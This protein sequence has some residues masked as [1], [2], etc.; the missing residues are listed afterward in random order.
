MNT[1]REHVHV[2]VRSRSTPSPSTAGASRC[3]FWLPAMVSCTCNAHAHAMHMHM[4]CTCNA[5]AAMHM[6]PCIMC[7]RPLL[8]LHALHP[9]AGHASRPDPGD[10]MRSTF[11][12]PKPFSSHLS[13]YIS[14]HHRYSTYHPCVLLDYLPGTF[15]AQPIFDLSVVCYQA[16]FKCTSVPRPL[17]LIML[18][19]YDHN[20]RP[21]LC[22]LSCARASGAISSA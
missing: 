13:P 2:C 9:Q 17:C 1:S 7:H 6:L 19:E 4:Q 12:L 22:S 14:P 11:A 21:L 3:P 16:R 18:V 20:A 15:F 10:V 5:H 8:S